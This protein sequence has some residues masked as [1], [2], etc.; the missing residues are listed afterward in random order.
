MRVAGADG[1]RTADV[2]ATEA[3]ARR[4]RLRIG[5]QPGDHRYLLSL[6]IDDRGEVTRST[7][8]RPQPHRA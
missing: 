8:A 5:Y 3:L 2:T 4:R 1:Q 7:Q 6:S